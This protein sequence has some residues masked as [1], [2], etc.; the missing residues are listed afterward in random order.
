[1]ALAICIW[2]I[3]N[4]FIMPSPLCC[5]FYTKE[6]QLQVLKNPHFSAIIEPQRKEICPEIF[7]GFFTKKHYRGAKRTS[8][9]IIVSER[10]VAVADTNL[11]ELFTQ[12]QN[13]DK[14]SFV[15]IY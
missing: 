1:L 10:G 5:I 2:W 13:G 7:S 4:S 9:F 6:N 8:L 15:C 3:D 12:N 14:E 11:W